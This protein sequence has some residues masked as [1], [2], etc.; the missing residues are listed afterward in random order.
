MINF[1]KLLTSKASTILQ[2]FKRLGWETMGG[3]TADKF[4]AYMKSVRTVEERDAEWRKLAC[5]FNYDL[6]PGAVIDKSD[7]QI[8][9]DVPRRSESGDPPSDTCMK[10]L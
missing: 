10:S 2:E 7:L 3:Y 6:L 8:S 4:L 1:S 9:S 5:E